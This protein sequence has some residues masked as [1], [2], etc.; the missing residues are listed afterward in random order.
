MGQFTL[1]PPPIVVKTYEEAGETIRT[2][3]G[4]RLLALDTETTGLSRPNDVAVIL[5]LSNGV[6]RWAVW[7][8]AIPFFKKFL[9]DPDVKIIGHNV[10]F[11]QWMLLNTGIDL[12]RNS[13]RTHYRVMDTMVMHALI[14]DAAPHDL[15]SLAKQYLGIEMVAFSDVFGSQLRKRPL[16]EVLLEEENEDTVANYASLDA[17][18]TYLLFQE[19]SSILASSSVTAAESPFSN[20]WEYYV[21]TEVPFTK[22]LW[23][24]ERTGVALDL[25]KLAAKG[26]SLDE[27][28]T[29]AKKWFY[30]QL[31]TFDINL[32]SNPQLIDLFIN[33]LGYEPPGLT[34]GGQPQISDAALKIWAKNGCKYAK[35]LRAYKKASKM[36]G[37]YVSGLLS[38][39]VNG[40]IHASYH[41]TGAR[42]GRLSSSDPNMQNQPP[43]V[44][45]VF[46]G[47]DGNTLVAFDYE[48]LEMRIL[49]H[50]ANEADIIKMIKHGLDIHSATASQMYGVS[51][52]ELTRIKKK[53]NNEEVL[54]EEEKA[55]LKL[56]KGA[57]TINFGL[58]Y[59]QGAGAL[60]LALGITYD[61]AKEAIRTYFKT[62]P[63]IVK[64]FEKTI[65][66]AKKA[67]YCSTILGRQRRVPGL[68][69]VL[70]SEVAEAERKV[71]NSPIQGT[72]SDITKLAMIKLYSSNYLYIAGVKM[73]AQVHDEIL[74]QVPEN[75]KNDAELIREIKR[76][77]EHPFEF[78]LRVPLST[79]Y[80]F[81]DNWKE[82]K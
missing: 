78:D 53:D 22:I 59:G 41:P 77:M 30:R 21:Q 26:P 38:Q 25:A 18:V 3:S 36:L 76:C 43:D 35:N 4:P 54:T 16:H 71:K 79:S 73:I 64:Y 6:E 55:L 57:K 80:K 37:T 9:E 10:N 24:M 82:A 42:T 74:F 48:Q 67:G 65:A 46:V 70:S 52:N 32:D 45:D 40:R 47:G 20:M 69:S 31:G 68:R 7:P 66:E 49:A 61:E 28:I 60:A 11:D 72:A 5:A 23:D 56:R 39:S 50:F 62:F 17:F 13:L 75:L 15:K 1:L 2:L 14:D 51:Y 12:N 8:S 63:N 19:F 58:M 44:R 81:G 33:K 29:K 27:E 34:P